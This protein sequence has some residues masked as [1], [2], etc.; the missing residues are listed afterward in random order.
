MHSSFS[1]TLLIILLVSACS[2]PKN[3]SKTDTQTV[4]H[5]K[6][7]IQYLADDKLEGRRTGT[8]GEELAMQYI[9]SQ[10]KEIG[11][12]AKG[13][14][15]YPQSFPVNDGK[16][17]DAVTEFII[18]GDKLETGRDFFLFP[19]SPNQNIEALPSVALQEVGMPWFFDLKE[20][21]EANKGNPH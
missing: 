19:F 3:I 15:S 13:T 17:M 1:K 7:H 11:L 20:T 10:F 12:T 16:Q 2:S 5:L 18:N 8:R 4:D 9:I 21:L 14:E 6:A